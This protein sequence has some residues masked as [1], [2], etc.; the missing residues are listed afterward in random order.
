VQRVGEG[1][2]HRVGR[3]AH[4]VGL[5]RALLECHRGVA[6]G[7]IAQRGELGGLLGAR[8]TQLGELG[9]AGGAHLRQLRLEL[10]ATRRPQLRQV[11]LVPP[12]RRVTH[13]GELRLRL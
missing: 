3:L 1:D 7:R 8:R 9:F 6:R 2:V 12:L 10:R 13:L 11:C 5:R 4:L